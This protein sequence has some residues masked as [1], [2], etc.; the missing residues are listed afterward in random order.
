MF[1]TEE[2]YN[3]TYVIGKKN[4]KCTTATV[5]EILNEALRQERIGISPHYVFLGL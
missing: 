3:L 2:N 1:I 4:G 5:K